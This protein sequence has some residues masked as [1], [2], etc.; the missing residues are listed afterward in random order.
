MN[1]RS[2]QDGCLTRF[3]DD[4]LREDAA[5]PAP[6][7]YF[8]VLLPPVLLAGVLLAAGAGAF[9]GALLAGALPFLSA[10]AN[11]PFLIEHKL[12]NKLPKDEL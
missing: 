9:A 7:G 3:A 11:L 12:Q 2:E 4:K 6:S 8:L 1:Q 5:N 10:I